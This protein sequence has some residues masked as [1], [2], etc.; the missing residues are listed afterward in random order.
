MYSKAPKEID[1]ISYMLSHDE[2]K[3]CIVLSIIS[4]ST[5]SVMEYLNTLQIFVN[6]TR[7]EERDLFSSDESYEQGCH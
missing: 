7:D 4:P 6:D 2:E 1:E 5:L 3:Q